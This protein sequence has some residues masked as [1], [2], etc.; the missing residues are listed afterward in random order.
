MD[1]AGLFDN[2]QRNWTGGDKYDREAKVLITHF[3]SDLNKMSED[4]DYISK[5]A[6]ADVKYNL[7]LQK[8]RHRDNGVRMHR[9]YWTDEKSVDGVSMTM[10]DDKRYINRVPFLFCGCDTVYDIDGKPGKKYET[11]ETVYDYT[12]F[13][14][15]QDPTASYCC[16]NCGD[17]NTV[18]RLIEDGCR[19]CKTKFILS[20]LYPRVTYYY[21]V[22]PK[23]Y[24]LSKPVLG[25]IAGFL[26]GLIYGICAGLLGNDQIWVI[27]ALIAGFAGGILGYLLFSVLLL[28]LVGVDI[29]SGGKKYGVYSR[30]CKKL[31]KFMSSY[32]PFFSIDFFVGKVNNLLRTLVYTDK[33]ED[34]AVLENSHAKGELFPDILDV[35]YQGIIGLNDISSDGKYVYADVN[36]YTNTTFIKN[37][38]IIR[39]PEIF[40]MILCRNVDVHDAC[41]ASIHNIECKS[42]GASFNAVRERKCPYCKS[43]YNLKDYDWIVTD[44]GRSRA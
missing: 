28:I 21:T 27:N 1:M 2:L 9:K 41:S 29:V 11:R 10:G 4:D 14:E 26:G 37:R 6:S 3:I 5:I 8:R 22:P 30:T 43:P 40:R 31:P 39:R 19:S 23:K 42:C 44:I 13:V 17:I 12:V 38:K 24:S 18:S 36:V 16:P 32:D 20:E 25:V 15:G 7:S 33:C 34:C 35:E